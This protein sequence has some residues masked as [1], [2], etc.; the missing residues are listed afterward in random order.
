[1]LN[2]SR[3]GLW[4][5]AI[6]LGWLS[7]A[8]A[9]EPT[10]LR[11]RANTTLVGGS[12]KL[13]LLNNCDDSDQDKKPDCDD[14]HVNGPQDWTQLE[15]IQVLNSGI[16]A[17]P[18]TLRLAYNASDPFPARIF[19]VTKRAPNG[20][21]LESEEIIGPTKSGP[22]PQATS[23]VLDEKDLADLRSGKLTLYAEGIEFA[24]DG[25][26]T[27]EGDK[28]AT[29]DSLEL[30]SAPLLLC[31]HLQAPVKNMVVKSPYDSESGRYVADFEH[32]CGLAGVKVQQVPSPDVWIEDELQ[33]GYTETPRLSLPV[34]L[35]MGRK[36]YLDGNVRGLLAPGTGY[37]RLDRFAHD[38]N[39]LYY[40]GDFEVTPPTA[41]YPYGRVYYGGQVSPAK[42]E[43]GV[44]FGQRVISPAFKRFFERQGWQPAIE[45]WTDW[46]AVGHVDEICTF[47]KANNKKGFV[48][49][50]ASPKRGLEILD[51]EDLRLQNQREGDFHDRYF[52]EYGLKRFEDLK[53]Q[54]KT[55]KIDFLDM[56][57][58]PPDSGVERFNST[59]HSFIHGVDFDGTPLAKSMPQ[60]ARQRFKEGLG[61]DDSEIVE[62]PVVFGQVVEPDFYMGRM[63]S[64]DAITPGIVNLS[65]MQQHYMIPDPFVGRFR[66]EVEG[67]LKPNG[68]DV[69]WIDDWYIYHI[70]KGEVHC[71]S[72]MLRKP[73]TT[74]WW[75][76][77]APN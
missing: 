65:A 23:Y 45:L 42:D 22:W 16:V 18:I 28:N 55:T 76:I 4:L 10:G 36:R 62:F 7:T 30:R 34:V 57:A 21:P 8:Q 11:L 66:D 69:H 74:K 68:I 15:P 58:A 3:M 41:K 50:L 25:R 19:R 59:V 70:N 52:D 63:W 60:S 44:A 64:A 9:A 47:I 32:N 6:A 29:L 26:L 5:A 37:Y 67:L 39:A 2:R 35:H 46:L 20:D 1:M 75:T 72:N 40:G 17:G 31:G 43:R 77:K 27:L 73:Y 48:L 51:L 54:R 53:D 38:N 24:A 56:A 12:P 33:W 14:D 61:L 13:L 71:G 49:A